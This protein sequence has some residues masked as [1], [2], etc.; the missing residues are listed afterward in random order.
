MKKRLITL[1]TMGHTLDRAKDRTGAYSLRNVN[2]FPKFGPAARAAA[3]GPLPAS[4]AAPSAQP[5]LFAAAKAPAAA[6]PENRAERADPADRTDRVP[7]PQ[8][9]KVFFRR[10]AKLGA[11]LAAVVAFVPK[12][13]AHLRDRLGAPSAD[14]GPRAQAELALEKVRV[15]RNDLSDADVVVVAVQARPEDSRAAKAEGGGAAGNPWTRVTAR[16]IKL[17][18]PGQ[19]ESLESVAPR[20]PAASP[21]ELAQTPPWKPC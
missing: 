14:A 2:K 3:A 12:T 20:A 7:P 21:A 13:V 17:K 9:P 10:C 4:Q 1:L 18:S 15:I 8:A 6:L 11:F 5:V 16:W 19:D